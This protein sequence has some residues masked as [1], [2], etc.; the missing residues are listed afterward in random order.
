MFNPRE[1]SLDPEGQDQGTQEH[2]FQ[3][4]DQV[5]VSHQAMARPSGN[6]WHG[7]FTLTWVLGALSYEVHCHGRWHEKKHLHVNDLREWVAQQDPFNVPPE[8][9]EGAKDRALCLLEDPGELCEVDLPSWER[10]SGPA[11]HHMMTACP[12]P[13]RRS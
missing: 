10:G 4:G 2:P 5:L 3:P 6:P 9:E 13:K 12:P 11:I 7:L 8:N 1:P